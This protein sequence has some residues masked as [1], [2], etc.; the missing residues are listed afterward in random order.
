MT[1][2]FTFSFFFRLCMC[3]TDLVQR[4]IVGKVCLVTFQNAMF[5]RYACIA[6]YVYCLQH[7]RWRVC[8]FFYADILCIINTPTRRLILKIVLRISF[9]RNF[10]GGFVGCKR[11]VVLCVTEY[12]N[13][14]KKNS[15]SEWGSNTDRLRGKRVLYTRAAYAWKWWKYFSAVTTCDYYE[16]IV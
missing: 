11:K 15:E 6:Q 2:D 4:V 13:K 1:S 10:G 9:R 7:T 16:F 3:S 14:T 12:A 8:A 5:Q